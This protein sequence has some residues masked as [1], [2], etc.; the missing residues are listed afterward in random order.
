MQGHSPSR[1]GLCCYNS[2][3]ETGS[4][5]KHRSLF[6]T[7]GEDREFKTLAGSSLCIII[8]KRVSQVRSSVQESHMGSVFKDVTWQEGIQVANASCIHLTGEGRLFS[9]EPT[10][11]GGQGGD[12]TVDNDVPCCLQRRTKSFEAA[13]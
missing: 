12:V 3:P 10:L 9:Q 6:L 1:S 8:W 11:M 2:L 4:F 13:S 7:I 5:I